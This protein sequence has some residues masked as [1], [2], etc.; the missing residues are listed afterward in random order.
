MAEILPGIDAFYYIEQAKKDEKFLATSKPAEKLI[1]ILDGVLV[2]QEK[3]RKRV[4]R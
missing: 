3:H 2:Y 1:E 4:E